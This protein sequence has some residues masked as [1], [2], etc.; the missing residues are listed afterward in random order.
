MAIIVPWILMVQY[1]GGLDTSNGPAVNPYQIS[2]VDTSKHGVQF[3]KLTRDTSRHSFQSPFVN[4]TSNNK[5]IDE[6][7]LTASLTSYSSIRLQVADLHSAQYQVSASFLSQDP[8]PD[9]SYSFEDVGFQIGA[10]ASTQGKLLGAER[11]EGFTVR[12]FDKDSGEDLLTTRNQP[13]YLMEH[14]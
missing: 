4:E 9:E 5:F 14:Y 11:E 1:Y 12:L 3:V 13:F 7:V 8:L 2:E 6:A 10:T